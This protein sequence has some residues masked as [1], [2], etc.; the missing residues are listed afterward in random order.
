LRSADFDYPLPVERIAQEP[1]AER[2]ASLLLHLLPDG[3]LE[4]RR[5]AD[6][7][8]LLRAGD[9]LV[10]NDT[11]VRR[12]RLLGYDVDGRDIELLVLAR[13]EDGTYECL[14]RP[15][16]LATPGTILMIGTDL[17]ATV[18]GVSATHPGGR[19]V[20]FDSDDPDAAIERHGQA[21][22]PPYIRTELHDPDRYQTIYATGDPGSAAAPT[23]GLHF[24]API[25]ERLRD[26]G[27]NWTTLR[28]DVGLATFAPIRADRIEDHPMHEERYTL[29]AAA[30]DTIEQTHRAGGRVI[31]VGTTVVR[32][33]ET[34]ALNDGAL[35]AGSGS[36]R[37]FIKPG[38]HFR[39]VDGLVTNFHQPRSSLLVLLA[40]FVGTDH[41]RDA[42]THALSGDYRFLSLG[43][44]ML[45]WRAA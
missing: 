40:A 29:P 14:A 4:D 22:L 38:H 7:P 28:L 1:L 9:L 13:A 27:I 35:H 36:T 42:Y 37:L 33:L 15:A 19:S 32:V 30:A 6:L 31:A 5:F 45:C 20:T 26:A 10:A 3:R 43:D 23:A 41:W 44:C 12:A 16:R 17:Q 18:T 25:I 11:R 2:D 24:T 34:C 8:N 39:I 21:P